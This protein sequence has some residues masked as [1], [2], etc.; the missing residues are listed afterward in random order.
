MDTLGRILSLFFFSS[1]FVSRCRALNV[2]TFNW[3]FPSSLVSASLGEC[4]TRSIDLIPLDASTSNTTGTPPYYMFAYAPQGTTIVSHL[5]DDPKSLSWQVQHPKGSKLFL[6]IVDGEGNTGGFANS[7]FDV[8]AG[9]STSCQPPAP[10]DPPVVHSN[11]TT[12]INTCDP[13]GLTVTG[14]VKPYSISLAAIRAPV[15][16]NVTMGPNDDVLIYVDRADPGSQILAAVVDATGQWGVSSIAVNTAGAAVTNSSCPGLNTVSTTTAA[17][18]SQEA[19]AKAAAAKAAKAKSTAIALG[20]VFGLVLPLI[21]A[22]LAFW[23]WRRRQKLVERERPR[24]FDPSMQESGMGRPSLNVDTS[25]V[26]VNGQP[27]RTA[28]WVVDIN[29][30]PGRQTDS[31]TSIDMASTE[32]RGS[33]TPTPYLT[34]PQVQSAIAS[35]VRSPQ[36][37]IPIS[38]LS[39][40]MSPAHTPLSPPEPF[41]TTPNSTSPAATLSPAQ[42]YRKALEAQAEAQAARARLASGSR[43]VSPSPS[44]SSVVVAGPSSRVPQRSQSATVP[45]Q[46]PTQP[47]PRRAGSSLRMP[48]VTA[49]PDDSPDIIFQ[50]SDGGIVEE[51][52]PPYPMDSRYSATP[53]PST[54]SPARSVSPPRG[55][56]GPSSSA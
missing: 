30:D 38:A 21:L 5:G 53:G 31:P 15:V 39:R 41:A 37:Q 23:Y 27:Q 4:E 56:A 1:L 42:R 49:L 2:H 46:F 7:F 25:V 54:L 8:V 36:L 3:G 29:Q 47:M 35:T 44:G 12:A 50:H 9:A 34:S 22:G 20:I 6:T 33:A 24:P 19:A 18:Q 51:L 13:W 43:S 10:K 32:I 52:P 16:T 26:R 17:I 40:T 28:S 11:V 14:G 45:R 55:S 48:P